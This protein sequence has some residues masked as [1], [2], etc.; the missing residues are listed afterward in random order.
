MRTISALVVMTKKQQYQYQL[1]V[2]LHCT[3]AANENRH[4]D[5]C[6]LNDML[7][8]LISAQSRM[9]EATASRAKPQVCP[10][11]GRAAGGGG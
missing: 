9:S 8:L 4:P 10:V 6:E 7:F 3:M 11:A 2:R 5:H 1:P